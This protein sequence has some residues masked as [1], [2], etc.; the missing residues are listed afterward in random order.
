MPPLMHH[1]IVPSVHLAIRKDPRA[2]V[3]ATPVKLEKLLL[4]PDLPHVRTAMLASIRTLLPLCASI[5][6]AES[7]VRTSHLSAPTAVW[8]STRTKWD[9]TAVLHVLLVAQLVHQAHG[10]APLALLVKVKDPLDNPAA[11]PVSVASTHLWKIRL[12]VLPVQLV[13]TVQ[14]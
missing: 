10:I 4:Q 3:I 5:V 7:T 9:L 12:V 14:E 2:S 11:K 1:G 6:S 13:L 8:V